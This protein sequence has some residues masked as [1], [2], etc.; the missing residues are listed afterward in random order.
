MSEACDV[1][2]CG[3]GPAGSTAA[4]E[5]ARAGYHTVLCDRETFPRD[6]TCAG[7]VN[8]RAFREFDFLHNKAEELTEQAFFGVTFLSPNLG[9]RISYR[10]AEP[11]GYLVR[12]RHFDH[13]LVRLAEEAGAQVLQGRAVEE[14]WQ[15]DE[16]VMVVLADGTR[17]RARF[18]VG[19]DGVRTTVGRLSGLN[20]GFA[21]EDLVVTVEQEFRV[22]AEV[23]AELGGARRCILVAVSY[24]YIPGYGWVFPRGETVSVGVGARMNRISNI[25]ETHRKFVSDLR[26]G[27]LLPAEAPAGEPRRALLPAGAALRG[28]P[29]AGGRVLLVGDAGGMVAALSGEG[30]YPGMRSGT[31]A[32]RAIAGGLSQGGEAQVASRYQAAVREELAGYLEMPAVDVSLMMGLLFRDQRVADKLARAFLFGEPI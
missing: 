22:P 13:A 29:L 28:K 6:K 25:G 31:A 21:E 32:A 16:A 11:Q 19:A 2:V 18:L 8:A 10:A 24:D 5:L 23:L 20:P 4:G 14:L 1:F 26:A 17:Y 12:R 9:Q 15:A 3:A 27:G 30:I 7:W